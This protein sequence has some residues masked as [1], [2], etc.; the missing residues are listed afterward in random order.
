MCE[1]AGPQAGGRAAGLPG[2]G[3][4]GSGNG[5]GRAVCLFVRPPVSPGDGGSATGEPRSGP[6]P[7][8]AAAQGGASWPHGERLPRIW[9]GC[10][11]PRA[12]RSAARC[13]AGPQ[14]P[15]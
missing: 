9:P 4:S 5:G 11:G 7:P 2:P 13:H 14:A 1:A 12:P 3:R 15:R 6:A 10:P 8:S